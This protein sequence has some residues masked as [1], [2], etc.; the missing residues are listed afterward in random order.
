M[1]FPVLDILKDVGPVVTALAVL[2]AVWTLRANHDWNRRQFTAQLVAGWNDKTSAHRKA[3]EKL[4]P[5]LIDLSP[6]DKPVEISQTDA[7][8]IFTARPDT[9]C[10][11][12]RFHFIE[13]LNHFESI[14]SAYRNHVADRPMIEESF[15]NVLIR[16]HDMGVFTSRHRTQ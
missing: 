14:A 6:D 13:L 8:E 1:A 12:L 15:Q 5:G 3:I 11:E 9:E 7:E 2:V 4:R 10:W 16:F